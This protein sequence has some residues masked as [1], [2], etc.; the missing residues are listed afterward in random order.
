WHK[1]SL[2][3]GTASFVDAHTIS[4]KPC[5]S[6]ECL[7]QG[8]VILI[9][10]GSY[11]YRPPVFPFH[12]PRVYDSDTILTLHEVPQSM[13][14]IGGGVIGCEYACMFA[15]LGVQITVIEKRDQLVGFL[16]EE[17]ATALR[18]RMERIGIKV[19]LEDSVR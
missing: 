11:P 16:D 12:D 4:V 7:I 1:I 3:S 6:P 2:Y 10:T 18:T 13:I 8:D 17:I 15:A 19:L 14:V 9:A 5:R